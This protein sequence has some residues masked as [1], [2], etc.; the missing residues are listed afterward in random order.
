MAH[1]TRYDRWFAIKF[2]I[3]ERYVVH[4]KIVKRFYSLL[5]LLECMNDLIG[6]VSHFVTYALIQSINRD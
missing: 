4:S 6:I 1:K 5:S 3:Y 2:A